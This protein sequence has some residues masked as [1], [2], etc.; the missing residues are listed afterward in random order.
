MGIV[1]VY[2]ALTNDRP[3][4]QAL[5]AKAA[6]NELRREAELGWRRADLVAKFIGIADSGRLE[7][8]TT[9]ESVSPGLFAST[10]QP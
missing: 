5:T 7:E 3:Y 2:D 6:L 9:K 1:D 4:R 8:I 10:R